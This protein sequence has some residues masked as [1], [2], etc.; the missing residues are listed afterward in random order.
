MRGNAARAS[1]AT[2]GPRAV[3]TSVVFFAGAK[4]ALSFLSRGARGATER[5]R[6]PAF[7]DGPRLALVTRRFLG[8][9]TRS[10]TRRAEKSE[11]FW[12]I[13]VDFF[14]RSRFP[15]GEPGFIF[16]RLARREEKFLTQ[17]R[18]FISP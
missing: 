14:A 9:A 2:R 11:G 4:K 8:L 6:A 16:P 18:G 15:N 7:P 1:L 12:K 13:S 3:D 5:R 17:K 10:L